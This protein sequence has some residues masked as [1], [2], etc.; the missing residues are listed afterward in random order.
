MREIKLINIEIEN[1]PSCK[2]NKYGNCRI[3][4]KNS[5]CIGE[6]CEIYNDRKKID[7]Y[8][9]DTTS[10]VKCKFYDRRLQETTP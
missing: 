10:R 6:K 9:P 4:C 1:C 2:H 8:C 5:F 7:K 3:N